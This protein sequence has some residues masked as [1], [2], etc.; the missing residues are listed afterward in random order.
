M[1]GVNF[2]FT[3]GKRNKANRTRSPATERVLTQ[4]KMISQRRKQP[5][6]LQVCQ[7]DHIRHE[8]I[9]TA[10]KL[11]RQEI[12]ANRAK[13]L[14]KQYESIKY[15]MEDLEQINSYLFHEANTNQKGKRFDLEM[16]IPTEYPPNQIWLHD[17]T[18]AEVA[19]KK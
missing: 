7:E 10:F 15:A 8:T 1:T 14:L 16:R 9:T 11:Y 5:K 17:Y 13:L 12:N 3:R 4:L 2:Q 19:E 6:L 18:P